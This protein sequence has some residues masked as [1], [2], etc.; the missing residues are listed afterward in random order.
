M[1]YTLTGIEMFIRQKTIGR[2]H[3]VE[4]KLSYYW[5]GDTTISSLRQVPA[6]GIMDNNWV[7]SWCRVGVEWMQNGRRMGVDQMQIWCRE[8]RYYDLWI[9]GTAYW[10]QKKVERGC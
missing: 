8:D 10:H 4:A 2:T 3:V 9:C 6:H 7:Q 1:L 5:W